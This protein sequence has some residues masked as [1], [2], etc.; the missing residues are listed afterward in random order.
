MNILYYFYLYEFDITQFYLQDEVAGY[1]V[2]EIPQV[3]INK[4]VVA[5]LFS[6]LF[7]HNV[8]LRVVDYLWDIGDK[9]KQ[10]SLNWS[11]CR[12][13]YAQIRTL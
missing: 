2:S 10:T 6:E 11:L 8:E 7:K 4:I 12:M 3:P 5:D 13:G 1:Y 9:V